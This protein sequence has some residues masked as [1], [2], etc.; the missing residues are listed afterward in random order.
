MLSLMFGNK[1]YATETAG[2][3]REAM[4]KV[5]RKFFNVA[6]PNIRLPDMEGVEL[7][8]A[9]KKMHPDMVILMITVHA[10]LE[11]AM[12]A[13]NEGASAYITKLLHMHEVLVTIREA[14]EKQ[15]PITENRRLYQEAQY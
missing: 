9:L 3:G 14:I 8:A 1:G 12:Q 7:L 2:T 5:E 13:L 6:L 10:S 4:N 15:R 11:T